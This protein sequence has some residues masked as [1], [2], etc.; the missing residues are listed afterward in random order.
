MGINELLLIGGVVL[1]VIGGGIAYLARE[2]ADLFFPNRIRPISHKILFG[3][4]VIVAI[5]VA[6]VAIVILRP[7]L[8]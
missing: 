4:L 3:G 8:A 2:L 5:G 6:V 7:L 1:I